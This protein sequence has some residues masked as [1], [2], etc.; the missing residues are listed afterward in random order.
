MSKL[1]WHILAFSLFLYICSAQISDK[2]LCVDPECN[3]PV[4]KAKTLRRYFSPDKYRL[5]FGPNEDVLIFSK[6]AGSDENLWGA[7]IKGKR[8]Y[9]P[10]NLVREIKLIS[11]PLLLVDTEINN[12]LNNPQVPFKEEILNPSKVKQNFE[13]IDGTTLYMAAETA[14]IDKQKHTEEETIPSMGDSKVRNVESTVDVIGLAENISRSENSNGVE[15]KAEHI[16]TNILE[17]NSQIENLSTETSDN[18]TV[19]ENNGEKNSLEVN[20]GSTLEEVEGNNGY[21]KISE[22]FTTQDIKNSETYEITDHARDEK[23]DLKT[24]IFKELNSPQDKKASN[25]EFNLEVNNIEENL[26]KE[27]QTQSD[28]IETNETLNISNLEESKLEIT[29]KLL[30]ADVSNIDPSDNS[31][32]E[33]TRTESELGINDHSITSFENNKNSLDLV[34]GTIS[35]NSTTESN[36]DVNPTTSDPV[37]NEIVPQDTQFLSESITQNK[38]DSEVQTH[39]YSE[40]SNSKIN[41]NTTDSLVEVNESILAEKEH[42]N[43]A[44]GENNESDNIENSLTKVEQNSDTFT[45]NIE[46]NE[47]L[48]GAEHNLHNELEE[49]TEINQSNENYHHFNNTFEENNDIQEVNTDN[50]SYFVPNGNQQNQ[51]MPNADIYGTQSS[52]DHIQKIQDSNIP[53]DHTENNKFIE[54]KSPEEAPNVFSYFGHHQDHHHSD[55]KLLPIPEKSKDDDSNMDVESLS[56]TNLLN[57]DDFCTR[58]S[59]PNQSAPL[60]EDSFLSMDMLSFSSEIFLYLVTTAVSVII[61]LLGHFALDK[62]RREGPLIVKINKLEKEFLILLKEKEILAEQVEN[63][64]QQDKIVECEDFLNLQKENETLK[65]KIQCLEEQVQ[66]LEKE[67]ENSTEVG[68]ELNRMLSEVL[69]SENAGQTLMLNIEGLQAQLAEQQDIVSNMKEILSHKETENHELNLELDVV[70]KK[71]IDLQN[72]VD[73]LL[74]N[75]IKLEEDKEILEKNSESEMTEL[76]EIIN[77]LRKELDNNQKEYMKRIVDLNNELTTSEHNLQLKTK[78]FD[79]LK[80]SMQQ[81]KSMKNANTLESLLEVNSIKAELEQLKAECQSHCD[82]LRREKEANAIL[83]KKVK[84][85]EEQIDVIKTKFDE[86][87]KTK[88]ELETKLL[89]LTNYF[90][91]KEE[92]LQKEL[93]KYENMWSTKQGEAT[94]TSERIKYLQSEVQN[95]KAQNETL[96]QEIVSQEVELKGQISVL[97]KKVHENWVSARQA[98]RRLEELKQEAAQLRN[99]LTLRERAL[100]EDRLHNRM[101]SPLEQTGDIPVS[102]LHLESPASPPLLF[103]SRD[104]ITKS[105]PILG[106]PPPFLPPPPTGASFLPPPPLPFMPPPP[107]DMFPGDHR[108]PPLGRMSSPPLN[109]RYSPSRPYSPYDRSP[110]PSYDESEYG[111]SPVHRRNYSQFNRRRDHR[112]AAMEKFNGRSGTLSSGSDNSNE[113][114]EEINHHN[115]QV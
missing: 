23:I 24:S 107:H 104:H 60:S 80:N 55:D 36:D 96:K 42:M 92:Q 74:L 46:L 32:V 56:D 59:C 64:T 99:R 113:S 19:N 22:T 27:I 5:S 85:A 106:M 40:N 91:E 47:K 58:E 3:S 77:S 78:E 68:L 67:L 6:S 1:C 51:N 76:K 79:G 115:S 89:V 63:N 90:K 4:S 61:F 57:K 43:L 81:I 31:Q 11:K 44:S 33:R 86:T 13:V 41:S 49:Q 103:N 102:P 112:L 48:S 14:D 25:E 45:D 94:S 70:N 73:K 20:S 17:N 97:E 101:Q 37:N 75:I 93:S 98:E 82:K 18:P 28:Q 54:E 10:K 7:E 95:Y 53:L 66:T 35:E 110:S 8:G 84:S 109:A 12:S 52:L 29:E 38:I 87:D 72:E 100:Q 83:E 34:Q 105:P 2:R 39:T 26:V 9:I 15:S 108:P 21:S 71:V 62:S 88:L 69:N 65:E 30:I 50:N 111:T 114:L 16:E